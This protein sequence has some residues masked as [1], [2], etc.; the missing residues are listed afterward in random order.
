MIYIPESTKSV[1]PEQTRIS[2]TDPIV[3]AQTE[4]KTR[5]DPKKVVVVIP[6]ALVVWDKYTKNFVRSFVE[7]DIPVCLVIHRTRVNNVQLDMV[8][9]RD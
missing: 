4:A 1:K 5:D 6:T 8:R 2:D 9:S 7:A 3:E